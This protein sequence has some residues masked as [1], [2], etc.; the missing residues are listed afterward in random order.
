[1][2][3]DNKWFSC[4]DT[5]FE[6]AENPSVFYYEAQYFIFKRDESSE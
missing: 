6:N 2:N 4:I 1:M 3:C 5:F